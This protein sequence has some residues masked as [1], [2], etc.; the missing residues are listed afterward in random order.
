MTIVNC[1]PTFVAKCIFTFQKS[2]RY[3]DHQS[4]GN[5][6]QQGGGRAFLLGPRG[7]YKP[8]CNSLFLKFKVKMLLVKTLPKHI[9]VNKDTVLLS[10]F[11]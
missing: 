5:D 7:L 3:I 6:E 9:G 1:T 8:N 11:I 10:S 4:A 2:V